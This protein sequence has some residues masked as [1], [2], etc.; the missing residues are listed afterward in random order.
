MRS[1]E[2]RREQ[3]IDR[4]RY[5]LC[6]TYNNRKTLFGCRHFNRIK[7]KLNTNICDPN[8]F[9][10]FCHSFGFDYLICYSFFRAV[11]ESTHHPHFNIQQYS[12]DLIQNISTVGIFSYSTV[13]PRCLSSLAIALKVH[14]RYSLFF[15]EE[16]F[17]SAI[18]I[19][20]PCDAPFSLSL[21]SHLSFRINC[22]RFFFYYFP[23]FRM[24]IESTFNRL[25]PFYELNEYAIQHF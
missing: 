1:V 19:C 15:Y 12:T 24:P 25:C 5:L 23:L 9:V 3:S 11:T 14:I 17:F 20:H 21:C 6:H 4:G 10:W 13:Y 7:L 8:V 16:F 18:F 22:W 2:N